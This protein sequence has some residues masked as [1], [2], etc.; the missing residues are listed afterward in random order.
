MSQ[1]AVSQISALELVGYISISLALKYEEGR[2]ITLKNISLLCDGKFTTDAIS[3]TELYMLNILNWQLDRPTPNEFLPYLFA[4]TC[5]DFDSTNICKCAEWFTTVALSDYEISRN[6]PLVIA[7][8]SAL[9]VL[10]KR[11]YF[12]FSRDWLK[13]LEKETNVSSDKFLVVAEL[14]LKKIS[15]LS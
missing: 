10:Q 6:P 5:E 3:T 14:I 15:S 2:E 13:V 12:E 1:K 9:C 8:A 7:V 11:N 4:F